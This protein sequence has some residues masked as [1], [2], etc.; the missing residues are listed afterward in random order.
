MISKGRREFRRIKRTVMNIYVFCVCGY[1]FSSPSSSCQLL[2]LFFFLS[3]SHCCRDWT[4]IFR[5]KN[6]IWFHFTSSCCVTC[7]L[8]PLPQAPPGGIILVISNPNGFHQ[9]PPF[10]LGSRPSP[11]S[12]ANLQSKPNLGRPFSAPFDPRWRGRPRFTLP[13]GP[14]VR[15]AEPAFPEPTLAA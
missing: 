14:Q 5:F 3:P 2:M 9:F 6:F 13:P 1:P 8:G 15:I 12:I 7:V 11:N 4:T 10:L